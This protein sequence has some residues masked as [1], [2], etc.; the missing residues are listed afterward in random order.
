MALVS[1]AVAAPLLITRRRHAAND[2]AVGQRAT[3][4]C[5]QRAGSLA[6][7]E[8]HAR[9]RPDPLVALVVLA[10]AAVDP[11][12]GPREPSGSTR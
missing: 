4:W 5:H 1:V 3:S 8:W 11:Q 10:V 6:L 2:R 9:H 12:A 7:L